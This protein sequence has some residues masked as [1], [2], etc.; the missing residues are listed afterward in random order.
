MPLFDHLKL[1]AS[2]NRINPVSGKIEKLGTIVVMPDKKL[3]Q[4]NPEKYWY[5]YYK[6]I[7]WANKDND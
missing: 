6:T 5:E 4:T 7:A 3:K 1:Q 2:L